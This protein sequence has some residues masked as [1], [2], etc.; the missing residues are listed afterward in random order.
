MAMAG[1]IMADHFAIDITKDNARPL[2]MSD[3]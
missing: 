3:Y 2:K 1:E